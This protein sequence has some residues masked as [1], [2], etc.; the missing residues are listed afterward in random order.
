MTQYPM[1][2]QIH[3]PCSVMSSSESEDVNTAHM[4]CIDNNGNWK[5]LMV[6]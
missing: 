5:E 6:Q 2:M 3:R 4:G 1:S